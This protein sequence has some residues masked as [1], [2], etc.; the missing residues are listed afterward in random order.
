VIVDE[1]GYLVNLTRLLPATP[2][3]TLANYM[4][5]RAARA[6]LDYFT[7]AARKIQLEFAKN[8]TGKKSGTER[9]KTC[10]G[11]YREKGMHWLGGPGGCRNVGV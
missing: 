4:M 3:R 10:T 9:W 7:E 6:S 5:W 1:P 11:G 2:A 8:I